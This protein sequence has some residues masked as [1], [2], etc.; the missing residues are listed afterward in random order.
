MDARIDGLAHWFARAGARAAHPARRARRPRVRPG[1][2]RPLPA[3][4]QRVPRGDARRLPGPVPIA[5]NIN[6]QYVEEELVHLLNDAGAAGAGL[7]REFAPRVAT[8]RGQV[9]HPRVLLQV[10]DD[11]GHAL[12]R[13][14]RRLRGGGRR[15]PPR[16]RRCRCR[17]GRTRFLLYTGGTTGMPKGVLWRQH[18]IYVAAM[19]GRPFGSPD[20]VRDLR[21]DRRRG[22]RRRRRPA[23]ADD[24]AVHARRRAV[25][26]VPHDQHRRHDRAPGQRHCAWT[27]PTGCAPA[28]RERV[29]SIPVVGRRDGAA[30]GRGDRAR[31]LRPVR[32]RG[33]QQRRRADH[34]RR[35][36]T[37]CWRRSPDILLLDAVGSSE[38]G[39]QMN[40]YSAAG[41]EARDRGLHPRA[42]HRRRRRPAH[43]GARARARARAGWRGAGWSRSATSATPEKTART[44]PVIDGVRYSVPG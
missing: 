28:E 13:R 38:T 32:A 3:Q 26:G 21:R 17:S 41:N 10:A 11:C 39:I 42:G 30:A 20:A 7:P 33:D 44:F 43:P 36:V 24:R 37:G 4:R 6:Y 8:I 23:P 2:R 31:R 16:P 14:R 18:D 40:H 12:P 9:P 29:L 5:F 19:G 25:V 27:R 34:A 1:P 22:P 15:T 35:P